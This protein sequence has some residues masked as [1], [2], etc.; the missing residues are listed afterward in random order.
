V[1]AVVGV[2]ETRSVD[3]TR[4]LGHAAYLG[5]DRDVEVLELTFDSVIDVP[6]GVTDEVRVLRF[7]GP[8]CTVLLE[9]H[10]RRDPIV[11]LSVAPAGPVLVVPCTPDGAGRRTIVWPLGHVAIPVRSQLTSFALRWLHGDHHPVRTSWVVV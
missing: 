2:P 4:A 8:D 5:H 3:T 9:V 1:I 11:K 6:D 10:G 7:A